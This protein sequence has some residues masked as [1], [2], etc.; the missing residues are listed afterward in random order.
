M[1][2]YET[3]TERIIT[4]LD[5]GI[6]PWKKEWKGSAGSGLPSNFSTG[7][8][9]RGINVWMLMCTGFSSSQWMTY[10]QANEM[11][12]QVRKGSKGAPIVFWSFS[13]TKD[14]VT[15]DKKESAFMR[16][17][18]VFNLDQIDGLTI[19]LP[20]EQ[21]E[22]D[23]IESADA[24]I[25]AFQSSGKAPR[26]DH[27][28]GDRAFYRPSSDSVSMPVQ[29]AFRTAESYYSTLFHEF[30]HSTGHPS[31]LDR[32]DGMETTSFGSESYSREELIAEF[33]A[34]F[35][36]GETGISNEELSTNH[37]AYIQGWL[38]SLKNDKTLAVQAAQ[39]AQKAADYI[40][41]RASQ[42]A[43]DASA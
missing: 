41:L 43:A 19:P 30:A 42:Q 18:T 9:Y 23:S 7:K 34:A 4:A 40:L 33:T 13:E 14:A 6:I 24:V 15:G 37:T 32:K 22:F 36:C 26:L 10:K 21:P 8:P 31:R 39:K 27:N 38:R 1:N 3:V 35:I 29:G 5:A 20:L 12:G 16:Q 17:Y 11:G 2:V 25:A 28:G